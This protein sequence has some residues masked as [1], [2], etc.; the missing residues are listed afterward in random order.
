MDVRRGG[1]PEGWGSD[2]KVSVP[3]G[4]VL[5]LGNGGQKVGFGK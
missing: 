5:D 4:V 3:K 1:V 2:G